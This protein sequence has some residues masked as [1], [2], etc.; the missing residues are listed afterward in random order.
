MRLIH[1][2]A[3]SVRKAYDWVRNRVRRDGRAVLFVEP[4]ADLGERRGSVLMTLRFVRRNGF[5]VRSGPFT[6]MRYRRSALLHWTTLGPRLAGTYEAELHPAIE[7]IVASAPPLVVNLGAGE[8]YYAVGIARRCPGT[9]VIA[10]E[11][12][13]YA[14]R[15]IPELAAANGTGERIDVRGLCDLDEFAELDPPEGTV[16]VCDCEGFEKELIDPERVPWLRRARLL[17]EVH[18][19]YVPGLTAELER[20][21]AS[22]HDVEVIESSKRYLVDHPELRATPGLSPIQLEHVLNELRYMR[23]PWLW[24]VPG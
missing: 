15:A 11:A 2:A 14:A 18:E 16:L 12:D 23:T 10:Y 17:V 9:R 13:P 8:G 20:R 4:L 21:L 1:S 22:T 6:G 5:V 19:S 24:A 3:V 7:A